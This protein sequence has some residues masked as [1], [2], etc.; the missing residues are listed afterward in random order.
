MRIRQLLP[1]IAILAL[2][3]SAD[4]AGRR[5]AARFPSSTANFIDAHVD[6]KLRQAHVDGAPLAGD[7]EFLRR[8]SIDLAGRIPTASEVEAFLADASPDKRA[9]KIDELLHSEGFADRWTLWFGDLMLNVIDEFGE[10]YPGRNAWQTWMRDSFRTGK[11][12]D[13]MVRELL[14]SEGD[15]AKNGAAHYTVRQL[16]FNGPRQDSYDNLAA[17]SAEKFL[18]V[19][20]FCIS[21]HDG[22]GHLELVNTYL[23]GKSRNDFWRMAAFF[24]RVTAREERETD[25]RDP[26][27]YISRFIISS[28]GGAE[29][30]LDTNSGNKPPRLPRD[31]D[32]AFVTPAF[33]T[34]GEEPR[35]GELYR[36]AYARMLTADRQFARATVNYLWKEMFGRGLVEPVN[37]FDLA[38]LDTQPSHPALLEEL[39]DTFIAKQ[40][41]IREL[42]RTIALSNAYQRAAVY[43][44]KHP[45]EALFAR[46]AP[47]RLMA[48][49]LLDAVATATNVPMSFPAAGLEPVTKAIRL[50]D[51]VD[52]RRRPHSVF[53]DHFG[54]GNRIDVVRSS[55]G[56]IAQ[57]L[58][59]MNDPIVT[60]RVRAANHSTVEQTLAATR[61]PA[62]IVDRLYLATLSR[63]PTPAEK[64]AAV[65]YLRAGELV[66]RTED[67]QYALINSLEFFFS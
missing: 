46:R 38:Q 16:Q 65:A 12:Y 67:L 42:L 21:C 8:I 29:Y 59:L 13:A 1:F 61:D 25:P 40:Y 57:A 3:V 34:T 9:R 50:P 58:A 19:P 22:R 27:L 7:T 6:A 10:Q 20:A 64:E 56:S 44:G 11:P 26:K 55:D 24:S 37:G 66:E 36:V 51:P 4:T 43:D 47:R 18:G 2:A 45:D 15:S 60:D 28:D 33:L 35:P 5:H 30:R 54:R 31:G 49:V 14:V 48:E 23:R 52:T 63:R 17:H 32:P 39:T 62:T 41:S 53:M